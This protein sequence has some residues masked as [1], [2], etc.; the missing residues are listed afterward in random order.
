MTD[1][2]EDNHNSTYSYHNVIQ[3]RYALVKSIFWIIFF[4]IVTVIYI[5][6][7]K[8]ENLIQVMISFTL[9]ITLALA[10]LKTLSYLKSL[11]VKT[12]KSYLIRLDKKRIVQQRFS[13]KHY[14]TLNHISHEVTEDQFKSLQVNYLVRVEECCIS[15]YLFT[16][17]PLD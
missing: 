17:K 13:T 14:V 9:L 16:I 6:E 5:T 3:I 8:I 4:L 12:K 10:S 2:V 11:R 7:T 15:K 1:L